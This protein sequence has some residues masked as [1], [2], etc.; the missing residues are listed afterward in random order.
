MCKYFSVSILVF[1]LCSSDRQTWFVFLDELVMQKWI[2]Y[3]FALGPG[4]SCMSQ[5]WLCQI[6]TGPASKGLVLLHRR[7]LCHRLEFIAITTPQQQK[8]QQQQISMILACKFDASTATWIQLVQ[9]PK[10][11][12]CFMARALCSLQC[13]NTT[14]TNAKANFQTI[15]DPS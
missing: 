4:H 13:L 9:W 3:L 14:T 1:Y 10:V 5:V 7:C 15:I 8:Q 12:G 2:F 6:A 11:K